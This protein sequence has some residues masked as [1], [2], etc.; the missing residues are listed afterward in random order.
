MFVTVPCP[1]V[2]HRRL[3]A[4]DSS[5][6]P[7]FTAKVRFVSPD[8]FFYHYFLLCNK[9]LLCFSFLGELSEA[10]VQIFWKCEITWCRTLAVKKL[11]QVDQRE[12]TSSYRLLL[13]P[14]KTLI[15]KSR[16]FYNFL[17]TCSLLPCNSLSG[18]SSPQLQFGRCFSP[19]P[20]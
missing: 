18:T 14:Q 11:E 5:V 8:L 3:E 4:Q 9:N 16:V 15:P 19:S 17:N 2:S 12:P 10:L 6:P 20:I 7:K 1:I 13:L